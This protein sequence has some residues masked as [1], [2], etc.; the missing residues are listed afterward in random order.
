MF[1]GWSFGCFTSILIKDFPSKWGFG[2]LGFIC[3]FLRGFLRVF[4]ILSFVS[5]IMQTVRASF[6]GASEF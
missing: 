5:L 2:G 3:A 1:R 6:S 4:Q